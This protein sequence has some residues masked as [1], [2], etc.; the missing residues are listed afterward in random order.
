[1]CIVSYLFCF[2]DRE[3]KIFVS[4]LNSIGK[5][6]IDEILI[7]IIEINSLGFSRIKKPDIWISR[8]L[9]NT[10][11]INIFSRWIRCWEDKRVHRS[12]RVRNVIYTQCL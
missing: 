9:R 12:A 11:K 7:I 1:M 2:V 3:R 5:K 8:S 10:R 6:R 4:K